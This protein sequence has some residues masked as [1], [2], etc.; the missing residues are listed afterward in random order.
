MIPQTE[1]MII[2]YMVDVLVTPDMYCIF[3]L[4]KMYNCIKCIIVAKFKIS[5]KVT[6]RKGINLD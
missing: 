2:L 4:L 5:L 3:T 6:E 1:C